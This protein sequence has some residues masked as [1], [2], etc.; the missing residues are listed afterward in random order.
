[1]PAK[2]AQVATRGPMFQGM[3]SLNPGFSPRHHPASS[4][5]RCCCLSAPKTRFARQPRHRTIGAPNTTITSRPTLTFYRLYRFTLHLLKRATMSEREAGKS[6]PH[7]PC[8]SPPTPFHYPESLRSPPASGHRR[9]A[10]PCPAVCALWPGKRL[11]MHDDDPRS[12]P[13]TRSICP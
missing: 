5:R 2:A 13:F 4:S 9:D 10:S 6:T 8:P 11:A 1:M 3:C 12:Y 7:P